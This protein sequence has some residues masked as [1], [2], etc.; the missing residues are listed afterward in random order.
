MAVGSV[1]QVIPIDWARKTAPFLSKLNIKHTYSEFP[2]GHG[3]APQNFY[4][5]KS[6]LEERIRADL[7]YLFL[8]I[9]N[10]FLNEKTTSPNNFNKSIRLQI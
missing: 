4:E 6:W 9:K 5:F 8:I 3:V 1:D 7:I 10:H 2:V